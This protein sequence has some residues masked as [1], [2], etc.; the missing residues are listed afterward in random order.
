MAQPSN[1]P[2]NV[3][4]HV[5]NIGPDTEDIGA[6]IRKALLDRDELSQPSA[7]TEAAGKVLRDLFTTA[8]VMAPPYDPEALA[9]LWEDSSSLNQNVDA[10]RTNI[11][12]LGYRLEPLYNFD[13]DETFE[14]VRE[15]MWLRLRQDA[16]NA[17]GDA[18]EDSETAADAVGQVSVDDITMPDDDM[19]AQE[20]EKLRRRAR[21]EHII[22]TSFLNNCTPESSFTTH[23]RNHRQQLEVTGNSYWEMLR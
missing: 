16:I 23:R 2:T 19:V 8:K 14:R 20:I 10:Y 5:L 1:G 9:R 13:A 6:E 15:A 21:L 22:L 11:D 12:G 4:A 17:A 18:Q 3:R 7:H